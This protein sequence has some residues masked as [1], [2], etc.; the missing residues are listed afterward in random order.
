[1]TETSKKEMSLAVGC[2]LIII[3]LG[4]VAYLLWTFVDMVIFDFRSKQVPPVDQKEE[5]SKEEMMGMFIN[6]SGNLCAKVVYVSPE[7]SSGERQVNCEE[8][9]DPSKSGT[10]QN[11]VVYMV[12][13]DA[14]T[15]RLMGRA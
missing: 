7:L 14:Q 8:Y 3:L 9:R 15:V 10:K 4:V 12:N 6:L 1:M 13:I 5:M 2:P 11:M